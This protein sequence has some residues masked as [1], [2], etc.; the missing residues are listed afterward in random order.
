LQR[1]SGA[2]PVSSADHRR[3]L[4]DRFRCD[5]DNARAGSRPAI[6]ANQFNTTKHA[7]SKGTS[8]S[9]QPPSWGPYDPPPGQQPP[10]WGQPPAAAPRAPGWGEP[11]YQQPLDLPKGGDQRTG[12]LP[13]H[14]MTLG[15][16]L[17]GAF[18][19]LKANLVVAVLVTAAFQL[20]L[21]V[22][23]AFL[24]RNVLGGVGLLR[25]FQDPSLIEETNPLPFSSLGELAGVLVIEGV[26]RQYLVPFLVGCA[27]APV[28]MASYSGQQFTP[29]QAIGMVLRR[30]PLAL[31]AFA[32]VHLLELVGA[33]FCF[34][35]AL[36]AMAFFALTAPA[37]SIERLGPINAMG[38]S[39]EL[40]GPRFWPV[41]GI[42]LLA[43]L[44]AYFVNSALGWVFQLPAQIIGLGVAWPL[45]ALGTLLPSLITMPFIA[46]VATLLYLDA[47]IRREGLD[48]QMSAASSSRDAG[49]AS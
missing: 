29:G 43:G 27:L 5:A 31:V 46:L 38:R 39:V 7:R 9:S 42:S 41:L 30:L 48:L 40:V 11:G 32:C 8:V 15:D 26:L 17:D 4:V 45:L 37:F 19:L 24:Q 35:P 10:G 6:V 23:S 20:P 18:K 16:I 25:F 22:V 44:I 2:L 1:E 12:P 34:L 21:D 14:P 36:I 3:Y 49:P 47:R 33:V 28:V 13:L